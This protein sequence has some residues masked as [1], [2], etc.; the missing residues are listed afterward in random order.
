MLVWVQ[1]KKAAESL[2]I[3]VE[4]GKTKAIAKVLPIII[5]IIIVIIVIIIMIS[6]TNLC[7]AW[8]IFPQGFV[9]RDTLEDLAEVNRIFYLNLATTFLWIEAKDLK[10]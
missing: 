9:K 2:E 6:I 3:A 4:Q 8:K 7:L 5:I 10:N 1:A